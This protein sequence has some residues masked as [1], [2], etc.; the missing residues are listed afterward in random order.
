MCLKPE[1][2]LTAFDFSV[3]VRLTAVAIFGTPLPVCEF[4]RDGHFRRRKYVDCKSASRM[5]SLTQF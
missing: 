4:I 2:L 3:P 5:N 1:S